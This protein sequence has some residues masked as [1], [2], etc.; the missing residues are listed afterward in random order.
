MAR[1]GCYAAWAPWQV[2]TD[3]YDFGFRFNRPR[4]FVRS[5]VGGYLE[6]IFVPGGYLEMIFVAV[7]RTASRARS[8][9]TREINPIA[10][11]SRPTR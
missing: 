6:M 4:K 10:L 11:A 1:K 5:P 2:L 8:G 7:R 3:S 9:R